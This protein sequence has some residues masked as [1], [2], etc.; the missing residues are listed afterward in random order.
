MEETALFP[1]V[2]RVP[3][4]AE[5][6]EATVDGKVYSP[7][8]R[9]R[10]LKIKREWSPGDTV[11]V[12]IPLDIRIVPDGDKD[13]KSVV[14]VRGPQVLAT[15]AEIEANGGIPASGWWG[16]TVYSCTVKQNGV[17][18][19]FQLVN[20]ADAGQNKQPYAVVHEGIEEKSEKETS[21][22]SQKEEH[23]K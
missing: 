13:T 5:G 12:K 8:G 4:W 19:A 23:K 20:F 1:L 18:K 11:Q 10:L 17:E 3:A 21:E 9:N 6:F 22:D 7:S 16:D 15:S 2:L 14:F